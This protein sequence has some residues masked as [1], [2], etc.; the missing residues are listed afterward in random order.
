MGMNAAE[1]ARQRLAFELGGCLRREAMR[2]AKCCRAP[3][4]SPKIGYC[5]GRQDSAA[6]VAAALSARTATA[7]NVCIAGRS[8][9][10]HRS[11]DARGREPQRASCR[12]HRALADCIAALAD[13]A[14]FAAIELA[15]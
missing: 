6:K 15:H 9:S 13:A 10:R 8:A 12:E 2:E 5:A 4:A 3:A 1:T 7:A 11:P 14:I